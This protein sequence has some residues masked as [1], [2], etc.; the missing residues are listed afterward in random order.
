[1]AVDRDYLTNGDTL[2]VYLTV[3]NTGERAGDEVTQAYVSFPLDGREKPHKLLRGFKRFRLDAGEQKLLSFEIPVSELAF[4]DPERRSWT[5]DPGEYRI[6]VGPSAD[7]EH[8]IGA[9][10]EIRLE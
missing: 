3:R 9:G 8:L 4:Y 1:V 6:L 5:I 2:R 7:E 10:F